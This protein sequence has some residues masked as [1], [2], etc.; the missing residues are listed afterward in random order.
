[1]IT[2]LHNPLNQCLQ[3]ILLEYIADTCLLGQLLPWGQ[4]LSGFNGL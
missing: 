3:T 4:E 2:L 1:M